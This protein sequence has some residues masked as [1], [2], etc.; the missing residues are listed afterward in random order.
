N[1]F[2]FIVLGTSLI[3]VVHFLINMGSNLGFLPVAGLP[4][5]FLSYGGSSLLTL[6]ALMGIIQYIK[7]ES[8]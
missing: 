8:R 6:A 2:K 7:I 4:F 3:L 5:P 1:D